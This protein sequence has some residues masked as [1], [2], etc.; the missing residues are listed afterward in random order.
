MGMCQESVLLP[1]FLPF[2]MYGVVS[3]STG[4]ELE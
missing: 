3:V 1:F 4:D 2:C